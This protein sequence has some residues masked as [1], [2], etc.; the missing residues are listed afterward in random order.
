MLQPSLE[1]HCNLHQKMIKGLV[2]PFKQCLGL[3]RKQSF[4]SLVHPA[5]LRDNLVQHKVLQDSFYH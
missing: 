3:D 1:L 2:S 5:D 4:V